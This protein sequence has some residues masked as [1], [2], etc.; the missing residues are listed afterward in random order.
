MRLYYTGGEGSYRGRGYRGYDR[1]GWRG[2]GDYSNSPDRGG[3]SI[4]HVY[5]IRIHLRFF[6]VDIQFVCVSQW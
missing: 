1:G 3:K 4:T 5:I 6:V 2:R